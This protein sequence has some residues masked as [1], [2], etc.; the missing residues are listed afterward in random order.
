MS[1]LNKIKKTDRVQNPP[2]DATLMH[3]AQRE[4]FAIFILKGRN[5]M[6]FFWNI[7]PQ[8]KIDAMAKAQNEAIEYIKETQADRKKGQ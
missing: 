6:H 4:N 7:L 5:N 1:K 2:A 8:D 3:H